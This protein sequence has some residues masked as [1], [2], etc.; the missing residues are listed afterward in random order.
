MSSFFAASSSVAQF[1]PCPSQT[2]STLS[3]RSSPSCSN[4]TF[5]SV[6]VSHWLP[7]LHIAPGMVIALEAIGL[8]IMNWLTAVSLVICPFGKLIFHHDICNVTS[9]AYRYTVR[10]CSS[11]RVFAKQTTAHIVRS[12]NSHMNENG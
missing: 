11:A 2:L 6:Q 8:W 5:F 4:F 12:Y 3:R 10:A 7:N 1:L 9:P